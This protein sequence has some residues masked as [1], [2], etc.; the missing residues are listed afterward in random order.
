MALDNFKHPSTD[1]LFEAFKMM[2]VNVYIYELHT[3]N[4]IYT[5]PEI[6]DLLGIAPE[7]LLNKG[8]EIMKSLFHPEEIDKWNIHLNCMKKLEEGK[9]QKINYRVINKE[10][11]V[12]IMECV[13]SVYSRD[14][15]NAPVQILGFARDIT[16]TRKI[17]HE[18]E[19]KSKKI[20]LVSEKISHDI[21]GPIATASGLLDLVNANELNTENKNIFKMLKA[22]I[23]KLNDK[24]LKTLDTL[25]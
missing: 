25:N 19:L 9:F 2:G 23:E 24:S 22:E 8:Y 4:T 15:N 21:R 10:K 12:I 5:S 6:V 14:E 13:E 3:G 7:D 16:N 17:A 20:L 18:L 1:I 11:K